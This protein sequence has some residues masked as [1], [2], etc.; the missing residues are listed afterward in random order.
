MK[1]TVRHETL[2]TYT[3]PFPFAPAAGWSAEAA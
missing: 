1:I 2:Y 3:A